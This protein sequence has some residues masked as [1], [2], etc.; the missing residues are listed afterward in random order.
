MSRIPTAAKQIPNFNLF[1]LFM[2]EYMKL[3]N[4]TVGCNDGKITYDMP[5]S[6]NDKHY[7]LELFQ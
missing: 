5:D 4:P 6:C 2:V 1:L 7:V 3:G